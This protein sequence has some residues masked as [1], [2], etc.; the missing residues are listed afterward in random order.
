MRSSAV[1]LLLFTLC[2]TH[3]TPPPVARTLDE[4]DAA[5]FSSDYARAR[6]AYAA[7]AGKDRDVAQIH[8]ANIE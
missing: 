1:A 4:G 5:A 6:R 8:L 3:A 2:C 7:V